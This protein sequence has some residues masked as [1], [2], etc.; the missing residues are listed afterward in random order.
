MD[1]ICGTAACDVDHRRIIYRPISLCN[2]IYELISKIVANKLKGILSGFVSD[3]QFG[4]F[5][6]RQIHD[7]V[8]IVQEGMHSVK[9]QKLLAVILTID[10]DKA[11]DRVNWLFLKLLLLHMGM[12]LHSVNWIMGCLNSVFF[13]VLING[14]PFGVFA[15]SR[16]LRQGCSLSVKTK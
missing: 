10:L 11:H 6:N 2:L 7:A 15:A 4:F 9:S 16:G 12:N 3:E 8:G 13:A 14:S 5:N 1:L